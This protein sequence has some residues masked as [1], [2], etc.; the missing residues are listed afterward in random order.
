MNQKISLGK[1]PYT[2]ARV[3]VMK[4]NLLKK[5]DY[6]RLL[7]VSL[8]EIISFLESSEYKK[9]IDELAVNYS[10]V[11]LME[12][13]LSSNLVRT[14]S[15][16]KKISS[17]EVNLLIES[18]LGLTDLW[19]LKTILRGLYTGL[20]I[21]E[22][23][24]MIMPAGK[25]SADKLSILMKAHSVEDFVKIIPRATGIKAEKFS[26]AVETFRKE[27][28]IVELENVL[29]SECY[30][31]LTEFAERIPS[32]GK[33]FK[34]ILESEIENRNLMTL[35]RLKKAG[36]DKTKLSSFIIGKANGQVRRLIQASPEEAS[37]ILAE[38][39]ISEE[40]IDKLNKENTLLELEIELG[41]KLL[42]K[43]SILIHQHPLTVDVIL[44]YMF[45]KEIEVKNLK[46]LLKAR[47]LNLS[48][49]FIEKQ[50]IV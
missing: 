48:E 42:K 12:M 50:I 20:S 14:W 30:K 38:M 24:P 31:N 19:N 33:L 37:I 39:K 47:Q 13:A 21:H 3:S 1:H 29:D 27:N 8:N 11:E 6:Q 34:Q 45:S 4:G 35:L 25:L 17:K 15:K 41:K 44:G 32:E 16:L 36:M 22:F 9:E 40:A 7:K 43:T 49:D 18:Y 5:E 46:M 28:R 2:Y 23:A 10:G 26:D